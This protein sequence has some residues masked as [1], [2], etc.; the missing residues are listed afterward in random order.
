M[1]LPPETETFEALTWTL[2]SRLSPPSATGAHLLVS[3]DDP[4]NSSSN[5]SDQL[6]E[7]PTGCIF[8]VDDVGEGAAEDGVGDIPKMVG[9][10]FPPG[11][12]EGVPDIVPLPLGAVEGVAEEGAGEGDGV[13]VQGVVI[14][15]S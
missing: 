11:A 6:P 14:L 3:S 15:G 12:E 8:D 9:E 10:G 5:A 7:T 1:R 2:F 4:L 13:D